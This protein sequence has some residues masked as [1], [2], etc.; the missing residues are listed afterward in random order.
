MH[1]TLLTR[2]SMVLVVNIMHGHSLIIKMHFWLQPKKVKVRKRHY[3]HC[4]LLTRQS[5]IYSLKVGMSYRWRTYKES[6]S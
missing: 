3:I 6:N 2:W 5:A 1:C 4:E